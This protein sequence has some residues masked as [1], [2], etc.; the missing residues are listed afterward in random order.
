MLQSAE[1][2][3]GRLHRWSPQDHPHSWPAARLGVPSITLRFKNSLEGLTELRKGVIPLVVV[4]T[5]KGQIK[6]SQERGAWGR[7]QGGLQGQ[8]FQLSSPSGVMQSTD[9]SWPWCVTLLCITYVE[10]GQQGTLTCASVFRA[11]IWAQSHSQDCLLAWLPF[12]S[13]PSRNQD[14]TWPKA[15]TRSHTVGMDC[16]SWPKA[17]R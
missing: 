11:F 6:I 7:V 12:V 1:C 5:V 8:A 13:C 16:L 10:S 15:P 4:S 9:F 14:T 17:P 2:A 3:C